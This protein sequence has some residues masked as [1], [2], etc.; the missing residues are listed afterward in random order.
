MPIFQD[1]KVPRL[2]RD[3]EK[4]RDCLETEKCLEK[5]QLC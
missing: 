4:S 5:P 3:F 1:F 2:D